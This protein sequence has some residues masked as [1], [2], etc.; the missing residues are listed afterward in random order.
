MLPAM[1]PETKTQLEKQSFKQNDIEHEY[2]SAD[3]HANTGTWY[4]QAG[5]ADEIVHLAYNVFSVPC[6]HP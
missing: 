6:R 5:N 1:L 2:D 4:L 3:F